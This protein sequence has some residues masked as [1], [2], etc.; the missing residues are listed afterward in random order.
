MAKDKANTSSVNK[1]QRDSEGEGVRAERS[2]T[3]I[4][5][6]CIV[7]GLISFAHP[8]LGAPIPS[9]VQ[10]DSAPQNSNSH[11]RQ[12]AESPCVPLALR[13]R[14]PPATAG[15]GSAAWRPPAVAGGGAS[16]T[17]RA[18]LARSR[19]AVGG[20]R[21]AAARRCPPQLWLEGNESASGADQS[22][23][24]C[25]ITGSAASGIPTTLLILTFTSL[26]L[27]ILVH[28]CRYHAMVPT[29]IY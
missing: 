14:S 18:C 15:K 25:S 8:A 5:L 7:T 19:L 12:Y 21:G 6:L 20:A 9:F 16:G 3:R 28:G 24:P 4:A 17:Q 2:V 13:S 27:Y 11:I 26:Y 1:V 22:K 29:A 23:R 10:G